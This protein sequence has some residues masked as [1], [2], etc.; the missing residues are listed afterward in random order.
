LLVPLASP[1]PETPHNE[2]R[3]RAQ[4]GGVRQSP[5]ATQLNPNRPGRSGSCTFN[6]VNLAW[7]PI[8]SRRDFPG[9]RWWLR[10]RLL[11]SQA[12]S[13][14]WSRATAWPAAA[15]DDSPPGLRLPLGCRSPFTCLEMHVGPGLCRDGGVANR[16]HKTSSCRRD[17]TTN[18]TA[19]R[20]RRGWRSRDYHT[21]H[22]QKRRPSRDGIWLLL[23][24]VQ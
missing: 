2:P 18:G 22:Q 19:A 14:S 9:W 1:G 24:I 10:I 3:S 15:D 20:L 4:S 13:P 12:R 17:L 6:L 21:R 16:S 11:P 5:D 23:S 7:S 8:R